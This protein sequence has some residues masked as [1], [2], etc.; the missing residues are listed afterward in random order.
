MGKGAGQMDDQLLARIDD[1]EA[2][3]TGIRMQLADLRDLV[4]RA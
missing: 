2:R 4:L 3:T 1:L